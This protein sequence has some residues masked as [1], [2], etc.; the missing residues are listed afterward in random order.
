MAEKIE[1]EKINYGYV[2]LDKKAYIVPI[3]MVGKILEVLTEL[4]A[5]GY[6]RDNYT[7]DA[8]YA[9]EFELD[10]TNVLLSAGVLKLPISMLNKIQGFKDSP[11]PTFDSTENVLDTPPED[12]GFEAIV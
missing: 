6:V 12:N 4:K 2:E 3:Y 11:A 5:S 8:G 1:E 9:T 7:S 10:K